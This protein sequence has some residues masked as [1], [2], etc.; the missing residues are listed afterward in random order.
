MKAATRAVGPAADEA[1]AQAKTARAGAIEAAP[2]PP[3]DRAGFIAAVEGGDREADAEEPG[4][5]R[6]TSPSRARRT[7]VASEVRGRVTQSKDAST[8]PLAEASAK[9]PDTSAR[10]DNPGAPLPG[11]AALAHA[12]PRRGRAAP[13]PAPGGADRPRPRTR[14]TRCADVGGRSHRRAA[15]ATRTSRS[16]RRARREAAR[17]PSTPA[18]APAALR[19]KEA[20]RHRRREAG[21]RRDRRRR[22]GRPRRGSRGRVS[23][24]ARRS[25]EAGAGR[26]GGQARAAVNAELRG[27]FDEDEDRGRRDPRRASTLRSTRRSRTGEGRPRSGVQAVPRDRDGRVQGPRVRRNQRRGRVGRRPAARARRRVRRRCSSDRAR[28]TRPR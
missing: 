1:E 27:I 8:R 20:R 15:A 25:A 9:P 12:C 14:A 13:A 11:A 7:T 26:G 23:R 4:G 2:T 28:S 6:R 24:A 18:T 22:G 19:A 21:C 3:F 17:S 16:S 5:G 10:D